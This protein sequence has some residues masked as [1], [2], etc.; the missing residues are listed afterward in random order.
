M[1][2]ESVT[3]RVTLTNAE[4][5]LYPATGTTKAEV[6]DY[7][8]RIAEVMLPHIA[9]RPATRKRWPNGVEQ[10]SFFEKQL[11]S[12]APG[13]LARADIQHRSGITTYPVIEDLDGLA[14]IAQQAALEVHVPQWRFEAQ[15][16]HGGRVFKPGPAT[17]LVFDLDPGEGVTMSQLA[18]VARA[19]RELMAELSL[20]T[21]PLTS[22]SKGVHVYAA[23]DPPVSS[24]GAVVLAKRV[25][26]QLESAMPTLVTATMA[27]KLRAG[28]VFLDWSQNN[29]SKTTIAP[30]SLRGRDHPTV[31]APR[32]W[33][34]LDDPDLRQLRYD[35]VL[36]RVARDGDLL[37]ALDRAL[38]A[39]D[40]LDVYRSKRDARR[41]PEPVPATAPVPGGGN[42]FVIQE[43]H[44]RRLHYDFRLERD[45][46]LVSWAVPKNLPE[47]TAVN[48]LAVRTEDHPLEYGSF[49]G[50]IPKGEYGAGTVRIWDSGTYVTE[51]FEDPAGEGAEKG[52]VIVVLSGSR[53]SGRYALIRT[54]GDQW[55]AHRMKDQQAFT[56]SE[57]APMLATHG[58]VTRLDPNQWAFE[59]K[60]DGYRLLVEAENGEVRL[61]ARS[62]RDVTA[63]YPQLPFPAED[64][65]E[66]HVVLDG[67]LVALDDR[68][69]PSFAAMQNSA[70]AAR[71][72]F[73]AFDLLYL[74]GRPLLRVAYRDRRRLLETLAQGTGLVVKELL[75]PDG[76]KALE[77]SGRLGWEGVIAKRWDSPYRPGRRSPAWIKDK[78]WQT[79]EVVIGGWR[80]GE[81]G[82]GGGIGS[83]L[84]GVPEADGLRF[85]GRVGT[86]FTER[87][88][89]A[90]KEMLE[91]LRTGES[92]FREPLARPDAKGV[93]FV[94]PTVVAEVRYSERTADGRLRQP[95][96]RGLRPDK[97]PGEVEWE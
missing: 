57:L 30:Y 8:T 60:W 7:Y 17:R 44:A 65:A 34:E 38:P 72:E 21:F 37:A 1:A 96:W 87:Q 62:G 10:S 64:L 3:T 93:T 53:I 54:A 97:T 83:L 19:V 91:P 63:E 4:K 42:S 22:G 84:M 66:H 2:A 23:L 39:Q 49:E 79:Q 75:T 90:L 25:A 14:W 50:T 43:H 68:G 92:P 28:K 52:E 26:Q 59:G 73:W 94:E 5:V 89:A 35:E 51:K 71:L 95:S 81:G 78:H 41:T 55:L 58:S 33:A 85:V 88:L 56:F 24:A 18:E 77:Q 69:V 20:P 80:A 27:K 45:G 70:R 86:G 12:S 13:W 31:A 48:H 6:F 9:G 36:Q 47:T 32:T 67:E 76:A 16:T 74:D 46:V 40:R 61:R 29:A 15:W 11:A 82:R